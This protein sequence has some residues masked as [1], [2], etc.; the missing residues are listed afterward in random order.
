MEDLGFKSALLAAQSPM[1]AYLVLLFVYI[2][3]F[4]L[5]GLCWLQNSYRNFRGGSTKKKELQPESTDMPR[6][7]VLAPVQIMHC[8]QLQGRVFT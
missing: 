6:I 4:L 3:C 5:T 1:I 8:E 2:Y 7:T